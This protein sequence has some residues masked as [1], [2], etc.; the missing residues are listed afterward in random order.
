MAKDKNNTNKKSLLDKLRY[1]Y[2]LI[3][4]NEDTFEQKA[5]LRLSRMNLYVLGSALFLFVVIL[6]TGVI[7]FTPLKY[8]M[9][10]VGSVDVRTQLIEVE[11]LTDSLER[12]L[13]KR[14][15]WLQS[16][17]K[18][19]S[20]ELDSTFFNGD[21]LIN[22][23]YSAV[24]IDDVSPAEQEFREEMAEEVAVMNNSSQA[25]VVQSVVMT[26]YPLRFTTPTLG[27]VVGGYDEAGGHRGID[28][29][30]EENEFVRAVESGVVFLADWNPETGY[31]L[32]IQHQGNTL[33]FYKHNAALLKKV[34][35]FVERGEAVA[36][37]GN[38][39]HLSD[40]P[41]LHFELWQNGKTVD[42]LRF[43]DI[44][45]IN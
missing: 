37:M 31:V 24:D 5:S 34:G 30:G 43:M 42:P 28:I 41:H 15:L 20:G 23:D 22:E 26:A 25:E 19:L 29:A 38:T 3:I 18:A 7:A 36:L 12:Q 13:D 16:F 6:V 44:N 2:R 40:G 21:S 39:G 17:Q 27:T 8:Y 33:S 1:K 35:N 11:M 45:T 4:L 9:P 10:G 14:N 32:G